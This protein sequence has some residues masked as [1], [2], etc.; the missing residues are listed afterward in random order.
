MI[1]SEQEC[2]LQPC[3]KVSFSGNDERWFWAV[4]QNDGGGD[5]SAPSL[6]HCSSSS[7]FVNPTS[8]SRLWMW[9]T[10]RQTLTITNAGGA[11]AY[12]IGLLK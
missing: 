12:S 4:A 9:G 1:I 8:F 6:P 3:L 11:T 7:D 10:K 5:V 2:L